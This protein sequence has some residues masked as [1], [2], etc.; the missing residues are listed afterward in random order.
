MGQ[1]VYKFCPR[2]NDPICKNALKQNI[3]KMLRLTV[4]NLK[5][6]E[7]EPK[8]RSLL[9]I[10]LNLKKCKE[11]AYKHCPGDKCLH[12]L[13]SCCLAEKCGPESAEFAGWCRELQDLTDC[14]K[15][16]RFDLKD[17]DANKDGIEEGKKPK[18]NC[19]Q[20]CKNMEQGDK[21]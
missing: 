9:C 10:W 5:I 2:K 19:I 21:G 4:N 12:C 15:D 1:P 20:G 6:G 7:K 18:P 13:T 16:T 3:L 17:H 14:K 8:R 11:Y